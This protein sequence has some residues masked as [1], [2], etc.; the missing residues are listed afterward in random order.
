LLLYLFAYSRDASAQENPDWAS[1]VKAERAF[2]ATSLAKGTR[3]AFLDFLAEDS[4]L[5]RPGPV[6][7]KKWIEEHPAPPSLLTWEPAFADVAQSGDLGY[8][9]GPWEIR[10]SSPQDKVMA[11]GHYVSVWKRQTDGAWKVVIDLG[12]SHPA[13]EGNSK[14]LQPSNFKAGS[15]KARRNIRIDEERSE[16]LAFDRELANSVS[17]KGS[18]QV[19]LRYLADNARLYRAKTLPVVGKREIFAMLSQSAGK[20][21]LRP[22][23]ADISKAADLGYTYGTSRSIAPGSGDTAGTAGNYVHIWKR[24]GNRWTLVL[25]VESPIPQRTATE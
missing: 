23:K 8:T 4:I 25:D 15:E 11:Y 19:Y 14:I 6:P 18:A 12:I 21:T 13:P 1:L 10:P 24:K 22:D 3:T 7:G 16:L 2:A 17:E 9:A 5:F 20:P